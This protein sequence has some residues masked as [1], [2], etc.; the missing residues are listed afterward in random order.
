[1]WAQLGVVDIEDTY[2]GWMDAAKLEI[3]ERILM[4]R[5]EYSF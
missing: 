4:T 1:M 2:R 3:E 5:M